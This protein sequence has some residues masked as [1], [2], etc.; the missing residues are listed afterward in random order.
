MA[1]FEGYLSD[2]LLNSQLLGVFTDTN[3]LDQMVSKN[4]A[5]RKVTQS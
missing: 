3:D 5:F 4:V 1:T 2:D